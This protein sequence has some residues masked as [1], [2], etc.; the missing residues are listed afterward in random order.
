LSVYAILIGVTLVA[1]MAL[2][3]AYVS[4]RE[5]NLT[6]DDAEYLYLGLE[7]SQWARQVGN[8]E[9]VRALY[10]TMYIVA[11]PPLLHAWIAQLWL[12]SGYRSPMPVILGATVIP[13]GLLA[14]GVVIVAWRL[15]SPR[16][17]L[18]ALLVLAASPAMLT[19]GALVMV[20]TLLALWVLLSCY[21]LALLIERPGAT[22]ALGL[23]TAVG[24]AMLTK[25]TVPLVLSGG[26]IYALYA[27]CRRHPIDASFARLLGCVALPMAVLDGPWYL[28]NGKSAVTHATT[29]SVFNITILGSETVSRGE[30]LIAMAEGIGG[31]TLTL[32]LIALGLWNWYRGGRALWTGPDDSTGSSFAGGPARSFIKVSASTFALGAIVLLIPTFFDSRFLVPAWSAMT[33]VLAALLDRFSL[34][35]R[36]WRRAAPFV[37]VGAVMASTITAFVDQHRWVTHWN[38]EGVIQGLIRQHGVRT[39]ASLGNT[40]DWN[41]F[42]LRLINDLRLAREG[43]SADPDSLEVFD[44]ALLTPEEL[45]RRLERIDALVMLDRS[46][47]PAEFLRFAPLVNRAYADIDPVLGQIAARFTEIAGDRHVPPRFHVYVRRPDGAPGASVQRAEAPARPDGA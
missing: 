28:K 10:N 20:E 4:A 32:V 41:F 31:W 24:L 9:H 22:I 47:V 17:A 12:L 36:R 1:I 39:L 34:E 13:F 11:K 42:K 6:W 2:V 14:V 40:G 3:A 33:V 46:Q 21:F 5:G 45:E 30:R 38:L 19:L 29:S 16:V 35:G 37:L 8:L 43:P 27:Y 25:L 18:L 15:F 23:G 7:M 44:L 26:I